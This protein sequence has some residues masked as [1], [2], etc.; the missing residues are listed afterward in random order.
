MRMSV[1]VERSLSHNSTVINSL[2]Y[3]IYECWNRKYKED[4]GKI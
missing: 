3:G 1:L 4:F 2:G